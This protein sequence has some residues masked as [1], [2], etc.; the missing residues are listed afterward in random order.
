MPSVSGTN[1]IIGPDLSTP[2]TEGVTL[3]AFLADHVVEAKGKLYANGVGWNVMALREIPGPLPPFGIGMLVHVPYTATNAPHRIEVRLH[4]ADGMPIG[5]TGP[6]GEPIGNEA[7][8]LLGTELNVGR[9][10]N[11]QPG[12]EQIVP[13]AVN[14]N[15]FVVPRIGSYR[16]D[17]TV[18]GET[19]KQ[20]TFRVVQASAAQP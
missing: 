14:L 15:G 8:P 17:L 20:L 5:P 3:D 18:D 7:D 12:E 19:A 10:P 2:S 9:P 4:D 16:F 6:G 11:L 1:D 13:M